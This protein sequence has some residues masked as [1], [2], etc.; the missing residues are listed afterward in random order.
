MSECMSEKRGEIKKNVRE[1][2]IAKNNK[3]RTRKN[4]LKHLKNKTEK[5]KTKVKNQ[6][7]ILLL[8]K[9]IPRFLIFHI[10]S[11]RDLL[12]EERFFYSLS[13]DVKFK[14]HGVL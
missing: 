13:F 4:Y 3:N 10:H 9:F 2:K 7:W 14:L 11:Y 6:T 12:Y 1:K 8:K 5:N